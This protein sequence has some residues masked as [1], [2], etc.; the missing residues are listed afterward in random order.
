MP[1]GGRG[2]PRHSGDWLIRG[3]A[4]VD[5]GPP[6]RS[7][8]RLGGWIPV[9]DGAA[10]HGRPSDDPAPANP[11]A[12][13]TSADPAVRAQVAHVLG[14]ANDERT[15][16][17]LAGALGDVD[18]VGLAAWRALGLMRNVIQAAVTDAEESLAVS[19]ARS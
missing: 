16:N 12:E 19:A 2:R 10:G 8:S 5:P 6:R 3:R 4:D 17:P 15:I 11:L 14:C 13:A 7:G 9:D 1:D 18:E